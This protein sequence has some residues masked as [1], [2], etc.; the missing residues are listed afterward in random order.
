MTMILIRSF[1]RVSIFSIEYQFNI[2]K[3]SI[4]NNKKIIKI[5][6]CYEKFHYE[7]HKKFDQKFVENFD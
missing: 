1:F 3:K 5:I 6:R 4:C 2:F 7:I